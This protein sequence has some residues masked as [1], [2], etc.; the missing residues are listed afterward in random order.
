LKETVLHGTSCFIIFLIVIA[1]RYQETAATHW[2]VVVKHHPWTCFIKFAFI[3]KAWPIVRLRIWDLRQR[4]DCLGYTVSE[5]WPAN[6]NGNNQTL[7]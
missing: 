3:L 5:W 2:V 6:I 1:E 7:L 4:I